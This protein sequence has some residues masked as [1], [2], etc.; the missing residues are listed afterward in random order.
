MINTAGMIQSAGETPITNVANIKA[1]VETQR[2]TQMRGN[3][4]GGNGSMEG[5]RREWLTGSGI[6]KETVTRC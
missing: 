3:N 2:D 6:H 5:T 4:G 1:N